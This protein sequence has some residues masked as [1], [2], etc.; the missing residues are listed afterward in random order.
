M[1]VNA[2]FVLSLLLVLSV[3]AAPA[4]A[5]RKKKRQAPPPAPESFES[6][7]FS[8]GRP[9]GEGWL[10]LGGDGVSFAL[11]RDGAQ[12]PGGHSDDSWAAQVLRGPRF[13]VDDLQGLQAAVETDYRDALAASGRFELRDWQALADA[14][15]PE[16]CLRYRIIALDRGAALATG[17]KGELLLEEH[18]LFCLVSRPEPASLNVKISRR[19][20]KR[21]SSAS[22]AE[23]ATDWL[24]GL[25]LPEARPSR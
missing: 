5:G 19:S 22:L 10:L 21:A 23:I 16:R 4:E 18:G 24:A 15:H 8:I 11:V 25:R 12:D 9:A 3:A 6:A 17:R 20:V 7:F 1:P 2:R 13:P 14:N